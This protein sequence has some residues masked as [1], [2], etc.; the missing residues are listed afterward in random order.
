[1]N[2]SIC[3][4][5]GAA[6]FWGTTGIFSK[7][8]VG[9]GFTTDEVVVFRMLGAAIYMA[10]FLLIKDRRLFK[11]KLAQLPLLIAMG[12]ISI[13]CAAF[14]YLRAIEASSLSIAAILMYTAPFFVVLASAPLFGEKLTGNKIIA[15]L[16]AFVGCLLISGSGKVS[17]MGIVYGMLSGVSYATYSIFGKYALKRSNSLTVS[18][19]AFLF[20]AITAMCVAN[21]VKIVE[22]LSVLEIRYLFIALGTGLITSFLPYLLYTLGL[23]HTEAGTASVMSTLE[24]LMATLVG[25]LCFHQI[26]TTGTVVGIVLIITAIVI[27]NLRFP[28]Q[29]HN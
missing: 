25:I 12:A 10:I 29:L 9:V 20:A 19:Y 15:L 11:I 16:I 3:C 8:L 22:K 23:K 24:P 7:T 2:I 6:I 17:T 28:K 21:P 4:I 5:L 14:A 13:F 27:I 26:P 1:M 18:M